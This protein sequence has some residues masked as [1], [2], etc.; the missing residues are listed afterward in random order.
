MRVI[1]TVERRTGRIKTL[2]LKAETFEDNQLLYCLDKALLGKE[3]TE[4]VIS[5]V[6]FLVGS[7]EAME[8]V[9]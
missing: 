1:E 7:S 6:E 5:S 8:G 2:F 3:P 4:I 9:E